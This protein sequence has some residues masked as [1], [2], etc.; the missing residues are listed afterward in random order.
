MPNKRRS[1][2]KVLLMP[3]AAMP[4]GGNSPADDPQ[5]RPQ[6]APQST[7]STDP[8]ELKPIPEEELSTLR[9]FYPKLDLP[10]GTTYRQ[11]LDLAQNQAPDPD[12]VARHSLPVTKPGETP[13]TGFGTQ[14]ALSVRNDDR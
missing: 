11:F 5:Q 13:P 2:S 3:Q 6:Q 1:F 12:A 7:D 9:D 8:D 4:A 14:T 10:N